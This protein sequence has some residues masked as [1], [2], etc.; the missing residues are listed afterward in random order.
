M[1]S[2]LDTRPTVPTCDFPPASCD[3]LRQLRLGLQR[4]RGSQS[5][6]NSGREHSAQGVEGWR[7]RALAWRRWTPVPFTCVP[8]PGPPRPC[9]GR[10]GDRDQGLRGED[11]V[12]S[13]SA[14]GR[15]GWN[16]VPHPRPGR[17]GPLE[18]IQ[19]GG[20]RTSPESSV[21]VLLNC[22]IP[23]VPGADGAAA[24]G[25]HLWGG[26]RTTPGGLSE[27]EQKTARGYSA[28]MQIPGLS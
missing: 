12:H 23:P 18:G 14:R 27:G 2:A 1:L 9:P 4:S 25:G 17:W 11:L 6:Q 22:P 3:H 21:M 5:S 13:H 16:S 28:K 20:E 15:R 10:S 8:I 19:D 7:W 24:M 26:D